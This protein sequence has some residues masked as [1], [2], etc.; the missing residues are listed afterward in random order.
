MKKYPHIFT[1]FSLF[2]LFF[3]S[4]SFVYGS[5]GTSWSWNTALMNNC[6]ISTWVT[7][8]HDTAVTLYKYN[9]VDAE[10]IML[11]NDTAVDQCLDWILY[12]NTNTWVYAYTSCGI[13]TYD[14]CSFNNTTLLHD[15]SVSAFFSEATDEFTNC[16]EQIRTCDDGVLSGTFINPSCDRPIV[17]CGNASQQ[18]SRD[19]PQHFLCNGWKPTPVAYSWSIWWTWTCEN[20]LWLQKECSTRATDTN[21]RG[22]CQTFSRPFATLSDIQQSLCQ[23]WTVSQFSENE[24]SRLWSCTWANTSQNNCRARKIGGAPNATITY[25]PATPT[26]SPVTATLSNYTIPETIVINNDWLTNYVFTGNGEFTFQIRANNKNTDVTAVVDR[27]VPSPTQQLTKILWL[28][29]QGECSRRPWQFT[30]ISQSDFFIDITSVVKHCIMH[31]FIQGDPDLFRPEKELTNAH[32]L[33]LSAK[34]YRK[35]TNTSW[36]ILDKDIELT[37]D[38]AWNNA[39]RWDIREIDAYDLEGYMPYEL[40]YNWYRVINPLW[41]VKRTYVKEFFSYLF[42]DQWVNQ[43]YID[44]LF[45]NDLFLTKDTIRRWEV[46]HII[47]TLLNEFETYALWHNELF[48][49]LLERYTKNTSFERT[50]QITSYILREVKKTN[51][52]DFATIWISKRQLI[53]DLERIMYATNDHLLQ[54]DN[55]LM[56]IPNE[57]KKIEK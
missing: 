15:Q 29:K 14:V 9:E 36:A 19:I 11:C 16:V 22:V 1:L 55:D 3:M 47:A 57:I 13:K 31:G 44:I 12:N 30:D 7:V 46:A 35:L 52:K 34:L 5:G 27:I 2:S 41:P 38:V 48:L 21:P 18:P 33:A 53:R 4:V 24:T 45:D 51:T 56:G 17:T 28:Y 26:T 20:S 40:A 8:E 50:R 43:D 23:Q 54:R 37:Y 25:S 32:F 39:M 42:V 49:I 6:L 10:D